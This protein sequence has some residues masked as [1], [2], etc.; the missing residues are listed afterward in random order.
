MTS[1]PRSHKGVRELWCVLWL[2]DDRLPWVLNA[3]GNGH[4]WQYPLF[5]TRA[6]ARQWVKR[7]TTWKTRIVRCRVE[8]HR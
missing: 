3:V 2:A 7:A 8:F 5:P 6:E 1:P 4:E